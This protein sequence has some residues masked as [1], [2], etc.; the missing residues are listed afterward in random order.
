[1][2]WRLLLALVPTRDLQDVLASRDAVKT[3]AIELHSQRTFK[4]CGPCIVTV[5]RD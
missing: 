2:I 5:N 3:Y 4:L 1:M